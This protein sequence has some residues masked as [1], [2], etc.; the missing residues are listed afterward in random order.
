MHE[1]LCVYPWLNMAGKHFIGESSI[2]VSL[3]WQVTFQL[4]VSLDNVHESQA[5]ALKTGRAL[6]ICA[7]ANSCFLYLQLTFD[8][9]ALLKSWN[10]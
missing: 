6:S 9:T 8:L 7:I 5:P 4:M 3:L 2:P 10:I 1:Q